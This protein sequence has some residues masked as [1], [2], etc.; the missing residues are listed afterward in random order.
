MSISNALRTISNHPLVGRVLWSPLNLVPPGRAL[1]V[2]MGPLRGRRWVLSS[3]FRSCWLGLYELDKQ[4]VFKR[5]VR[6]G[7]VVYDVGANV[8]YYTL[9]GSVLAGSRGRVIAFEPL[10]RNLGLLRRHVAL[11]RLRNVTVFAGAVSDRVGTAR[12]DAGAI[13]EMAHLSDQGGIEVELFQLDALVD[14]GR[15]PPPDVMK[16]DVE[17]AELDVLRGASRLIDAHR[18]RMLIA[19]HYV[20]VHADVIAFLEGRGYAV[21]VL[22]APTPMKNSDMAIGE[23]LATPRGETRSE[24]PR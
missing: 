9:V 22:Q 3:S 15:V 18:P 2:L 6:P 7:D 23:V 4:R 10:P 24:A 1:P 16:I 20:R 21:E 12:F 13:P 11:N 17:G 14:G 19:T 8:G 5:L